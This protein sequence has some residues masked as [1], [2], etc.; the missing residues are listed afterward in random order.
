[1]AMLLIVSMPSNAMEENV[2]PES[3]IEKIIEA[4]V[5]TA[6]D[7]EATETVSADNQNK[8]NPPCC[9]EIFGTDNDNT[10]VVNYLANHVANPADL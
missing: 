7:M 3:N 1:M 2:Q 9:K 6:N 10:E 4:Q 8:S 5:E